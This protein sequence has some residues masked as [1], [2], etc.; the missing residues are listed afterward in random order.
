[1]TITLTY[2]MTPPVLVRLVLE[3]SLTY[4]N[5]GDM[6]G[7]LACWRRGEGRWA[8]AWHERALAGVACV[9]TLDDGMHAG[10]DCLYWLEVVPALRGQGIGHA[11]LRWAITQAGTTPL[12][13]ATTPE[14]AQFYQHCLPDSAETIPNLFVVRGGAVYRDQERAASP[15]DSR[16]LPTVAPQTIP[17]PAGISR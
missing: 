4:P 1:M 5:D 17:L 8:V 6:D 13:I 3:S 15:M 16:L 7:R 12:V 11:L 9:V 2:R 10:M 14:A